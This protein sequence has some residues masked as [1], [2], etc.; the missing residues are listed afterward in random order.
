MWCWKTVFLI[1]FSKPHFIYV[2]NWLNTG[3]DHIEL[4]AGERLPVTETGYRSRFLHPDELAL[5]DG[6]EGFVR[7]WLDER[8]TDKV[9][10]AYK[11]ESRQ[12]SFF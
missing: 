11:E 2:S 7:Q 9:W 3:H 8:A 4:R 1:K 6:P 10:L 5:F 12:L